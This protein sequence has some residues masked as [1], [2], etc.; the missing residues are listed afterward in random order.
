MSTAGATRRARR[1][2]TRGYGGGRGA[3]LRPKMRPVESWEIEVLRLLS[4]Q[5]PI[6]L[7]QFARFLGCDQPRGERIARH[8]LAAGFTGWRRFLVD[9]PAWV[10][11]TARG[12][13][14]SGTGLG[15]W[16][17][18]VG[19]LPRARAVNEVRLLIAKRAPEARWITHRVLTRQLRGQGHIPN[20][21]VEIGSERHAIEVE[22]IAKNKSRATSI[23][24]SHHA[25]YD[26]VICFCVPY[27]RRLLTRLAK[28]N[29][30]PKLILRDLPQP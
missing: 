1:P 2:R 27:T 28:Q 6:P 29:H 3:R 21:L 12:A 14:I 13:R 5:G 17:P 19:Q 23:I 16:I 20:G 25:R 7:D 10:W 26:A 11:A 30:W 24:Y 18:A 4:E 9:E 15:G 8:L 22:L